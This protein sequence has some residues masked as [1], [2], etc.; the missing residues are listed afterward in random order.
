MAGAANGAPITGSVNIGS[1]I[2]GTVSPVTSLSPATPAADWSV[3]TGV[4][5]AGSPQAVV[6]AGSTGS[7]AG[8]T[9]T[10]VTMSDF[11]FS[12]VLSPNPVN[13]WTIGAGLFTFSMDA[14]YVTAQSATALTLTG[15][16]TVSDG[17]DTSLGTWVFSTQGAAGGTLF[18]WSSVTTVP[19]P[20]TAALL[21]IGLIGVAAFRRKAAA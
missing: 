6:T 3:A 2:F 1:G 17:T 20:A 7:F 18:N 12:P 13:V 14:V 19:T 11:L 8:L 21:G 15:T 9:G 10:S 4:Q 5:F 16:G